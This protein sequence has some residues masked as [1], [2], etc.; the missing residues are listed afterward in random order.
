M[1]ELTP[2]Q[3]TWANALAKAAGVPGL[4]H[5]D[6]DDGM[7]VDEYGVAYASFDPRA[8]PG[9]LTEERVLTAM[10][11]GEVGTELAGERKTFMDDYAAKIVEVKDPGKSPQEKMAA[12]LPVLDA[13]ENNPERA[14][15]DT[16]LSAFEALKT[17][18]AKPF[19]DD[20]DPAEKLKKQQEFAKEK[21]DLLN[22]M[23]RDL[24]EWVNRRTEQGQPPPREAVAM[25]DI[26]QKE[27]QTLIKEYLDKGWS[28]PPLADLS[29][30]TDDEQA[31]VKEV[32]DELVAGTGPIK[33]PVGRPANAR[34]QP[35]YD[36]VI[37]KRSEG[38][39]T[40]EESQQFRVEMLSAMARLMGTPSGRKLIDEINAVGKDKDKRLQFVPRDTPACTASDDGMAQP[41][42]DV[43]NPEAGK[44]GVGSDTVVGY[45]LGGKDS[46]RAYNMDDGNFLFAPTPITLGHEMVHALHNMEGTNRE[47]IP[48]GGLDG[49]WNNSEEYWTIHKG[50]LSEQ[51]FR[52]DYGL[53]A[54]RFGHISQEPKPDAANKSIKAVED[55]KALADLRAGT[56]DT[57]GI[58]IEKVLE[59]ERGFAK[60]QVD[61]MPDPIKLEIIKDKTVKG[62]LPAGWDPARLTAA[63]IKQIV[64]DGLPFRMKMLGWT[65]YNLPYSGGPVGEMDFPESL[66]EIVRGRVHHPRSKQ[67]RQY[68]ALGSKAAIDGFAAFKTATGTDLG[69]WNTTDWR[70]NLRGLTSAD[71]RL[72]AMIKGVPFVKDEVDPTRKVATS[73]PLA[74]KLT[75]IA[76][77]FAHVLSGKEPDKAGPL[78]ADDA[79]THFS[80]AGEATT[81]KRIEF[82]KGKSDAL[83]DSD[84]ELARGGLQIAAMSLVERDKAAQSLTAF[85]ALAPFKTFDTHIKSALEL[86]DSESTLQDAA[87]QYAQVQV[88][89]LTL[90]G[91]LAKSATTPVATAI[92]KLFID[93][94][95]NALS[96]K[97]AFSD[98]VQKA[99][100]KNAAAAAQMYE[101]TPSI[102]DVLN[103]SRAS[104]ALSDWL[105]T[106]PG[107]KLLFDFYFMVYMRKTVEIADTAQGDALKKIGF[108]QDTIV[109]LSRDATHEDALS[110]ALAEA[111][112]LMEKKLP[113]FL[114]TVRPGG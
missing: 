9:K 93:D 104:D 38:P 91:W 112:T 54:M 74:T 71:A 42:A 86:I 95:V 59:E 76:Q 109:K 79:L 48:L 107:G 23:S 92:R 98:L 101:G 43:D 8:A 63:K 62:P 49:N 22:Q 50:E 14:K 94:A 67:G 2:E 66:K 29:D 34:D 19:P 27:H 10:E 33:F 85:K 61:M 12:C 108:K 13:P 69:S 88:Q 16:L 60:G 70:A 105:A 68:K 106:Q 57:A 25:S 103:N 41:D 100:D 45:K 3:I 44:R 18:M 75:R 110:K 39:P 7:H 17:E 73:D 32:W 53:S 87:N 35:I 40:A 83:K 36:Y 31:H 52:Q 102:E 51:T 37:T 30:M 90:D 4:I 11:W 113:D 81:D 80:Y 56:D 47:K 114:K 89:L 82:L 78:F 15:I 28:P 20:M 96:R 26:V 55:A 64:T 46:F 72:N 58:D 97:P 6:S 99:M 21:G 111:H 77:I 1:P 24:A 84:A 65:A 5:D